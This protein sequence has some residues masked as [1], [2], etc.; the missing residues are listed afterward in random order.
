MNTLL[1]SK[2]IKALLVILMVFTGLL[3]SYSQA[4]MVATSTMIQAEGA[5]YSQQD[6]QSALAST[7]LKQQLEA[8][9]VDTDQLNDRVASLTPAEIQQLNV[10]LAEQPAGGIVG[11]LLTIFVVFI[12]TDMLCATDVFSFVHCI[13]K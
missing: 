10:E 9:G 8:L 7:E 6:L 12:I 3:A 13:N 11:V 2:R 1:Q 5:N 4:G